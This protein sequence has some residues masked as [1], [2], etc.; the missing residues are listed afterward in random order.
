MDF[1]DEDLDWDSAEKVASAIK[2]QLNE[3]E[4]LLRHREEGEILR[5]GI[6]LV[7]AGVPNAGKSSLLNRILGRNRAIV[8]HIPG[9]TR[10][11]L[12]EFAQI[13]GI[14]VRL[15]DT[16][17]IRE[18]HNPIEQEGVSRSL[19]SLSDAH[20]ILWVIDSTRAFED[21]Q[22]DPDLFE[23]KST[24]AVVNKIDRVNQ[25]NFI[26]RI[27]HSYVRVSAKTG[28]GI[29]DLYDAIEKI[30]WRYPHTEEPEI[31][32][33]T[34]HGALIET[35]HRHLAEGLDVIHTEQFELVAVCLRST[36]DALG[37]VTGRTIEPDILGSIFSSF[38][39]G[40]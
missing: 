17:G 13:R 9:T 6:R 26:T 40:K 5:N 22:L 35:A 16:A 10:D 28:E 21:Q 19:S 34:R 36:L 23:K 11:T 37:K 33:N 7:I 20:L 4:E 25:V 24:I 12:E 31:L 8:T 1:S 39:I 32:I 30:V 2:V 27:N 3:L 15:I 29:E 14:P 18:S 38:C